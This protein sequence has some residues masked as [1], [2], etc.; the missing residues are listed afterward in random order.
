M[1]DAAPIAVL[2]GGVG[3]A[4]FLRGLLD[5]IGPEAAGSVRAIVNVADDLVLHGLHISPDLDTV[6]YT[7]A[8]RIDPTRGWGL[9]D[10]SWQAMAMLESL[11]GDAWFRLGD[12]DL[13]THLYRTQRLTGGAPLSQV[14]A[15]IA[16]ALGL[17]IRI[18]P[19]SDDPVRTTITTVDGETL[20]FQEYFVGR[21]HAVE[22]TAVAFEGAAS[23]SPAPGVLD[24]LAEAG[25]IVIAPSNPVV[26]IGPL[27][28]VPGVRAALEAR[29]DRCVAIS[30]L[31]GGAAL[32]GPAE[33]LMREQGHEANAVGVAGLYAPLAATMVI[34]HA[35]ADDAERIQA[36]GMDPV[37][38]DTIMGDPDRARALA[39]TTL[40]ACP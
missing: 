21:Q 40:D 30:P 11:G 27:L 8:D 1:S 5:A 12:R 23:A 22:T 26:S 28:A 32:K 35:D 16:G 29:R 7:L 24:A 18:I 38:T 36:L 13:G 4:R 37:V 19:V 33:R 15:E 6:M 39:L 10:E 9:A 34:D 2:C 25:T 3:A 17:A 20:S 14:T 31:V